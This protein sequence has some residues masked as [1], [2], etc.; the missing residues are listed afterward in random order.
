[1][2]PRTASTAA[3]LVLAGALAGCSRGDARSVAGPRP[4]PVRAER[5]VEKDVP[6]EV[7]AVGRIVANQ[8]V[9]VRAQV[10]GPIV[11]V[12]FTE[13]QQV[14]KGDLL[15]ELDRRPY[16]AALAGARARL[17]QD[18]A[19]AENARADAKR[20]AELVEKEY[21][22]RQQHDAARAN[23]A[24]LDATVV[25]DQAA[26]DRAA[27]D[28]SYCTLRAPAAGRTGRLLV[29][30]GNLVSSGAQEPLVTIE[31]VKPVFAAFSIPERHLA[32]LR[33]RVTGL[34]VR[35]RPAGGDA[36]VE[37]TLA[38]MDNAVDAATGTILLKARVENEDEALLPGQ[39]V[40][41]F[42]RIAE[43]SRAIVVPASAVASGQQ[44]DYA[45]VVSAERKAVL[46]PVVVQQAGDAETVIGEGI[47][48][49]ELVVTEGQLKLRPDAPVELLGERPAPGTGDGGAKGAAR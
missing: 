27:L 21:V 40:D 13:G 31:Q 48:A 8:S 36:D 30:P 44:G 14:K 9:A 2:T 3:A 17:E 12:H 11:A 35:V 34:P 23:A 39:V 25:A 38:F 24:A 32:A 28:L 15:L 7:R 16:A 5:A 37:A 49:G 6:V 45:Y 26:V 22:T 4:V 18:R 47:A 29:H 20:Y 46:R 41:V 33:G 42:L 43:R 10:S 1:M 19:R